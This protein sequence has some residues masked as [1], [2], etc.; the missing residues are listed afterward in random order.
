MGANLSQFVWCVSTSIALVFA[1]ILLSA[2][3]SKVMAV[4]IM[5]MIMITQIQLKCMLLAAS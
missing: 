1:A 2:E 3:G 5:I 4:M